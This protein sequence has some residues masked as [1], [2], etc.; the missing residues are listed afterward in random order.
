MD[1]MVEGTTNKILTNTEQDIKGVKNFENFPNLPDANPSQDKQAANKKYVDYAVSGAK[2]STS[3]TIEGGVAASG[4]LP[5]VNNTN[6]Y[7]EVELKNVENPSKVVLGS[8]AGKIFWSGT[9]AQYAAISPKDNNTVYY[10]F[11]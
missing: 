2:T 10:V 11:E 6:K 5:N 7:I 4:T 1:N 9:A 3:A 8:H